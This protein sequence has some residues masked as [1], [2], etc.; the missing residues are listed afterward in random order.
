MKNCWEIYNCGRDKDSST[1]DED[2]CCIA[3]WELGHSCWVSAE[4]L[5]K[6]EEE[7][8]L[9]SPKVLCQ[10]C[11]VYKLYNRSNGIYGSHISDQFPDEEK[12]YQE[13]MLCREFE[14]N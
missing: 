9:Y 8:T 10:F 7:L 11:E 12:K 6:K 14:L 3:K 5:P 4:L 2:I 13:I 1:T